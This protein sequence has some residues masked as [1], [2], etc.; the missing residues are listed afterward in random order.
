VSPSVPVLSRTFDYQSDFLL[1]AQAN[2]TEPVTESFDAILVSVGT[3]HPQNAWL[4]ALSPGGRMVVPLTATMSAMN[5]TL[6]KGLV[7]LLTKALEGTAFAARALTFISIYSGLHLRDDVTNTQLGKALARGLFPSLATL[8]RDL[9]DL[10]PACWL[11]TG[12]FCL[13]LADSN[14]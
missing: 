5:S 1:P 11:H 6:S 7:I 12:T 10:G 3:T 4:D 9:H 14:R 2:S 13:E 8:R